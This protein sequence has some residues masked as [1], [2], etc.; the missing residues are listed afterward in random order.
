MK[1]KFSSFSVLTIFICLSI[2]G[3]SLIPLL[4]VQL[5]PSKTL[6][7]ININYS[8]QD[9][10]AKVMEQEVTSKLEGVFN[11]VK[12][13]KALSSTSDKGRGTISLKFKSHTNMDAVRFELANLIRQSYSE[14]PEGVSYP[15][16][17]LSA[18]NK[19][20]LPILSYSIHANE[21][22]YYIK[23]YAETH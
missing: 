23:K 1:F 16:L 19:N 20:K 4:S 13:I 22:P 15:N 8:W 12:G 7:S 3:A 2:I 14:L 17:S 9:A 18:A 5:T 6:P 21:S 11:T 10:S